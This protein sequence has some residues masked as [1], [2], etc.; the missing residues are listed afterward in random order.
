MFSICLESLGW[1]SQTTQV[2]QEEETEVVVNEK[3]VL[4]VVSSSQN[5]EHEFLLSKFKL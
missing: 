5:F 2:S 3:S 4:Q 1:L